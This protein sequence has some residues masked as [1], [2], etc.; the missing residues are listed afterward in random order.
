[1]N[2]R[3]I[4]E[5]GVEILGKC[6]YPLGF[7]FEV[8]EANVGSGGEY[9]IGELKKDEVKLELHFRYS[10]GMVRYHY[11]TESVSHEN[12]M[13]VL[14]VIDQCQYPGFSK[15]PLDGFRHLRHDLNEF[16][17]DFTSGECIAL[18]RAAKEEKTLVDKMDKVL[19]AKYKGDDQKR[20]KGKQYFKQKNYKKCIAEFE[21]IYNTELLTNSERKML[22]I[23]RAKLKST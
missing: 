18:L 11:H 17:S 9:A 15:D 2:S 13:R 6:L 1:M 8:V 20:T 22:E 10:L 23:A 4:L 5:T 16:G 21:D 7:H 19:W 12:Y 14:G 3:I